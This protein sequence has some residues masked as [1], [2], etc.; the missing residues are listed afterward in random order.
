M[1][2]GTVQF[3]NDLFYGADR[4]Y[5]SRIRLSWV[6]PQGEKSI[7]QVKWIRNVLEKVSFR[8]NATTRFGFAVGQEFFTPDDRR[9][10]D[11]ITDD[12]P[13]AG[14]LYGAMS[15][16]SENRDFENSRYREIESIELNIGIVGPKHWARKPR[17]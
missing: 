11:L 7:D 12:R 16:H 1:A 13:Y 5:T 3:E 9:R 2:V 10:T 6:S 14:W 4:H 15:L 17:T 8:K